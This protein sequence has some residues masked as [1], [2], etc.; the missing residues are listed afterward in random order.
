VALVFRGGL[1]PNRLAAL[2]RKT[3]P[4]VIGRVSGE[5]FM[6]DIKA[7]DTDD[8]A[9]LVRIIKSVKDKL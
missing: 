5:N 3:D 9:D 4:P 2:F 7:I 6:I 8:A 1:S